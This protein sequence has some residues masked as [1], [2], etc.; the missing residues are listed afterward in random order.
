MAAFQ[1]GRQDRRRYGVSTAARAKWSLFEKQ[2]SVY[3]AFREKPGCRSGRRRKYRIAGY[4]Q[5]WTF[6]PMPQTA[7]PFADF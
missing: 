7:D 5:G 4:W 1:E 6:A 3:G 2:Y